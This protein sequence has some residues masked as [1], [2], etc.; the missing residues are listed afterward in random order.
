MKLMSAVK[1]LVVSLLVGLVVNTN[2]YAYKDTLT[3]EE[4]ISRPAWQQDSDGMRHDTL[5][6]VLE[7]VNPENVWFRFGAKLLII[8]PTLHD[9]SATRQ[10][11]IN[12]SLEDSYSDVH[13]SPH[14][15]KQ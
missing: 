6:V 4:N 10:D 11:S 13:L 5:Y 3:V 15:L 14:S 12:L 8:S 7:K 9:L 2:L 1:L